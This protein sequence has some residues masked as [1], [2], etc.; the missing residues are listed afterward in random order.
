MAWDPVSQ[1]QKLPQERLFGPAK[2]GHVRAVLPAAEHGTEGNRQDFEQVVPRV[3]PAWIIKL[4]ETGCKLLHGIPQCRNSMVRTNSGSR[5]KPLLHA[6]KIKCDSP[7]V[8]P[9]QQAKPLLGDA[10]FRSHFEAVK[11]G[12]DNQ[13]ALAP[14]RIVPLFGTPEPTASGQGAEGVAEHDWLATLELV[15]QVSAQVRQSEENSKDIARNAQAYMQHANQRIEEARAQDAEA[16]AGQAEER[17]QAA[18]RRAQAAQAQ[19][20]TAEARAKDAQA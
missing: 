8:H 18:E 6:Q 16:R 12:R 13:S 10:T 19:A 2:Q 7:G 3:V 4:R 17:V 11:S 14:D 1:L 15:R 20:Q 5:R 9:M